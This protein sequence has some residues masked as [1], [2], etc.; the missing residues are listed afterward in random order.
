MIDAESRFETLAGK[1]SWLKLSDS[2]I[3]STEP[4]PQP[5]IVSLSLLLC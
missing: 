3:M 2:Q 1:K 5:F 4:E